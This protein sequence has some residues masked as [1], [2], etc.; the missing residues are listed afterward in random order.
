[1]LCLWQS[2]RV[3][4]K[5]NYIANTKEYRGVSLLSQVGKLYS[6]ILNKLLRRGGIFCDEQNGFRKTRSCEDHIFS[7]TSIIR[8]RQHENKDTF[9]AFIV[10]QK[11]FNWVNR[12]LL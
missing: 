3:L 9:V 10:M 1:M 2:A 6:Q 11:A 5:G 12:D 7:L 8:N 4:V